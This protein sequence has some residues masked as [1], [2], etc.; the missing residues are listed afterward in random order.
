MTPGGYRPPTGMQTAP[1]RPLSASQARGRQNRPPLSARLAD[2]PPPSRNR[3]CVLFLPAT[4][5]SKPR[6][7][8]VVKQ[9]NVYPTL[10]EQQLDAM[11]QRR[12]T[13]YA[14]D[15]LLHKEPAAHQAKHIMMCRCVCVSEGR[16]Q[17]L[18]V[19]HQQAQQP[20]VLTPPQPPPLSTSLV[21]HGA[22]FCMCAVVPA[23]RRRL[24]SA[25]PAACRQ[26]GSAAGSI[27]PADWLR[28]T[29][30]GPR[31]TSRSPSWSANST[32]CR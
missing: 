24:P 8:V 16:Q 17:H 2:P 32:A 22:V 11:R 25:S 1:C 9:G 26:T 30:C 29:S 19:R 7:T 23:A 27:C 6:N 13:N 12:L 3:L 4:A 31:T 18:P 10:S 28:S 5:A 20:C 21:A 14:P 15:T